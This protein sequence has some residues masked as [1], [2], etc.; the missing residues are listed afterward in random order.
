MHFIMLAS[1]HSDLRIALPVCL[2]G[3]N[4]NRLVS[5][6]DMY[7]IAAQNLVHIGRVLQALQ[8]N[9]AALVT[10]QAALDDG[11]LQQF[12]DHLNGIKAHCDAIKLDC[13]SDLIAWIVTEYTTKAHT[14]GQA[15]STIEILST[16]FEQ[17]LGRRHFSYIAPELAMHFRTMEQFFP[18]R[19]S[20]K[21]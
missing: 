13:T 20:E 5:L 18:I 12:L 21:M 11:P 4:P 3:E 17:E 16:T 1:V 15:R 9:P 10:P 14:H 19:R 2:G 8:S 7:Q 6:L